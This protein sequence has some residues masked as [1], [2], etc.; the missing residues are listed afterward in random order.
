MDDNDEAEEN[1]AGKPAK[2]L[3]RSWTERHTGSICYRRVTGTDAVGRP[4]IMFQFILPQGE[5]ELPKPIYDT[6][7]ELKHLDRG[8]GHGRGTRPTGLEFMLDSK[9]GKYWRLPDNNTGRTAADVLDHR[10]FE[11]AE[12]LDQ[13]QSRDR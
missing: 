6:I 13:E 10:L 8:S 9:R 12:R 11:L 4:S 2:R 3:G 1:G 7:R 5:T